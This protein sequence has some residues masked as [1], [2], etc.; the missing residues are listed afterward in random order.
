M[1]LQ[2]KL[3]KNSKIK[4][5]ALFAESTYLDLTEFKT[6]IPALNIALSG[7]I[8]RGMS[9]GLLQ[10][11]GPSKHFKSMFALLMAKS[12]LN[13]NKDG[14]LLMYDSERGMKPE[15]LKSIGIDV[16]KVIHT[17]IRTVE[18]FKL[19]IVQQLEAIEKKDKVFILVDSIGN[20]ASKKEMDDAIDGKSV[21]DMSR[22]KSIKS[23]F[24][25]LTPYLTEKDIPL[26]VINHTYQE[27]GL[28]PK[29]IVSG[30]T[31]IYY[32]SQDI[33]IIGKSQIKEGTE[34]AGSNFTINIEKSRLVKE[35]SKIPIEVTFNGGLNRYS[36]ILDLAEDFKLVTSSMGRYS[37][38]W[39]EGD[40]KIHKKDITDDWYQSLFTD[41]EFKA[42]VKAKYKI[43][44]RSLISDNS[45]E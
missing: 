30:G 38:N 42:L 44:D 28:F 18:D 35:K 12:F 8:D 39:I 19:D 6:E 32:S 34:F 16:S 29:A 21:G 5:T 26:V 14:V 11:A 41:T 10:I 9:S 23:V 15:Y 3:I 22:A 25:I 45:E 36:G 43:G 40:K 31:G 4:E 2:Q 7:E 27:Q 33:W 20:L 24:R 17:P 13:E 1:S 37:R